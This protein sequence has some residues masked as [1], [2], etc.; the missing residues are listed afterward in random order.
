MCGKPR[1]AT[2]AE[3]ELI[4]G[5]LNR[6]A[7]I[8]MAVRAERLVVI[9]FLEALGDRSRLP[10][11]HYL[12]SKQHIK[13][14]RKDTTSGEVATLRLR[15][16][17]RTRAENSTESPPGRTAVTSR[18]RGNGKAAREVNGIHEVRLPAGKAERRGL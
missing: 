13:N 18:D 3:H 6:S 11:S 7:D 2:V 15:V 1:S 12:L 5:G 10:L 14:I 9:D 17:A 4:V 8:H 16:D